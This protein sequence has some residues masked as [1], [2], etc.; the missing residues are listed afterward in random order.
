MQG[1]AG[2]QYSTPIRMFRLVLVGCSWRDRIHRLIAVKVAGSAEVQMIE[3]NE[4]RPPH[5]TK[6]EKGDRER[7]D[8]LGVG[9]SK[10]SGRQCETLVTL[11]TLP[12]LVFPCSTVFLPI[13]ARWEGVCFY[14]R[15]STLGLKSP[16][17]TGSN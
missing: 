17:L 3:N 4:S 15:P 7:G 8:Q 12:G 16:G 13:G 1:Q 10:G 2:V 14:R 6:G 5:P 9:R 11:L